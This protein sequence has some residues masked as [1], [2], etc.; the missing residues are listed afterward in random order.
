[1][2]DVQIKTMRDALIEKIYEKMYDDDRIFFL[3][4]DFGAPALDKLRKDFTDR[5]INVGIAEQNLINISA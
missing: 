4:A 2:S 3:S 1:M 5:F